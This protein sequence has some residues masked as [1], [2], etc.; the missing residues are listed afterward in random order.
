MAI[1]QKLT[2]GQRK[3]VEG[4]TSGLPVIRPEFDAKCGDHFLLARDAAGIDECTSSRQ[5]F[6]TI[7]RALQ[8]LSALESATCSTCPLCSASAS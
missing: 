4:V 2:S 3:S 1:S 7:A 6:C 5:L 8:V